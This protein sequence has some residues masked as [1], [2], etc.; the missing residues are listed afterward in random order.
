MKY[1]KLYPHDITS[2]RYTHFNTSPADTRQRIVTKHMFFSYY[3]VLIRMVKKLHHN[4]VLSILSNTRSREALSIPPPLTK[5]P[6]KQL[7]YKMY[8]YEKYLWH[9]LFTQR[10]AVCDT[11]G[12][13]KPLIQLLFRFTL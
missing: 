8:R 10:Y 7:E 3:I 6:N 4:V 2:L 9:Q 1:S 5:H 11:F 13:I 12:F